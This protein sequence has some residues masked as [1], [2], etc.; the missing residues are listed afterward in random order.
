MDPRVRMALLGHTDRLL[1]VVGEIK[2]KP[3]RSRSRHLTR[4]D[5]DPEVV[6]P[7]QGLGHRHVELRRAVRQDPLVPAKQFEYRGPDASS[8]RRAEALAAGHVGLSQRHAVVARQDDVPPSRVIS[9]AGA[10]G[11]MIWVPSA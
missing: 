9:V 4:D 10:S 6:L 7:Q 3:L 1:D 11:F 8:V 5:D 2:T